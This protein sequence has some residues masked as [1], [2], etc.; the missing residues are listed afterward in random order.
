MKLLL[1]SGILRYINILFGASLFFAFFSVFIG[2]ICF[3]LFLICFISLYLVG[4]FF[5]TEDRILNESFIV[6]PTDGKVLDI[7]IIQTLPDILNYTNTKPYQLILIESGFNRIYFKYSPVDG[8][9]EDIFVFTPRSINKNSNF[10]HKN[11]RTYVCFKILIYNQINKKNTK[12]DKEYIFIVNEVL[13]AERNYNLYYLYVNK[14]EIVNKGDLLICNH[15]YSILWLYIPQLEKLEV[16]LKKRQ[17]L[18][19]KETSL[20][21]S[22]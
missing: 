14:G 7:Q 13:F 6:S 9:V 2:F 12:K 21:V 15:F 16:K 4:Y 19:Y 17:S 8:I 5:R 1:N 22:I 20:V 18:F 3:I 10:A 11:Y